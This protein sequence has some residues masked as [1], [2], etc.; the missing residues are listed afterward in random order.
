MLAGVAAAALGQSTPCSLSVNPGE[1]VQAALDAAGSAARSVCGRAAVVLQGGAHRLPAPLRVTASHSH[2]TL[3]GST[4][5]GSPPAVLDGG[6]QL[7]PFVPQP[8]GTWLTAL[9][10]ANFT[11][12]TTPTTLSVGGVRRQRARSPNA[13]AGGG[14]A[15]QFGD[16]ATYHAAGPLA[17]CTAPSWGSCPAVDR[18]GFVYNA[19]EAADPPLNPEANVTDAFALVFASWTAEWVPLGAFVPANSSLMFSQPARTAVGTYGFAPRGGSPAGGRFLLENSRDFLDAAGEW[20]AAPLPD[21]RLWYVPMPGEAPE[22]TAA[23]A[24]ALAT[25]VNVRGQPDAPVVGFSLTDVEVRNWGEW[26]PDARVGGEPSVLAA[27]MVDAAVNT[28]VARVNLHAGA[29]TGVAWGND[30]SGLLLDRIAAFDAGGVGIGALYA[31][32]YNSTGIVISNCSVHDVGDVYMVQPAGIALGGRDVAVLHNEVYSVAYAGIIGVQPG[33]PMPRDGALRDTPPVFRIAYNNV[34][35]YGLGVLNDFGGV[36]IAVYGDCWLPQ[37]DACWLP[38]EVHRNLVSHGASYNYGANAFY[39]DQAL[40]GVALH[41]NVLAAVGGTAI[42]AHCGFNNTGYNNVLYAPQEQAVGSREGAFGGCNPFGFPPGL[43]SSYA[44]T[45]NVV[46]LVATPWFSNG[47]FAPPNADYYTPAD[48]W[49]DGN[50]FFGAAP[51]APMPL[52]YPN[53]T[54]GL[55]AWRAAWGCDV[56]SVEADPQLANPAAGDFTLLP[57][58]PAWALGWEA[59]DLST[60]GPLPEE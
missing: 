51:G 25:I 26:K 19:S 32:N 55:P 56:T 34:S 41:H 49:S 12:T 14:L 4:E 1:S 35:N 29:S 57:T 40:S 42:E 47:E 33:G 38:A 44:F 43:N 15:G 10:A 24:A 39:S 45:R 13:V 31:N 23:V 27:V 37:N 5:P 30:V 6:V 7:P 8:D 11:P 9:P 18:S 3:R 16:V 36:Y 2:V 53:G 54:Q 50:V 46:H 21:G 58:S 22:G 48:W 28:T 52:H 60:V 17:A 20:Y 59:I